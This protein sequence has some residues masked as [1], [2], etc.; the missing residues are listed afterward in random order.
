MRTLTRILAPA[1]ALLAMGWSSASGAVDFVIYNGDDPGIGFNDPTPATPVGGNPGTTLGQQRIN[2]YLRAFDLWG[3]VLSSSETVYV[4]AYWFEPTAAQCTPTSGVLGSA[5]TTF[6]FSDFPG[7]PLVGHWYHSSLA[8]KLAGADL[9]DGLELAPGAPYPDMVTQFNNNL[10]TPGCLTGSGWYYG[11]DNNEAPGQIDFLSVLM[12]E[13]A[14][15][16]GFSNFTNEGSGAFFNGV[17]DVYTAFTRDNITGKQ[18]DDP[19]MTNADRA[20]SGKSVDKMVWNGAS[21]VATADN[22]LAPYSGVEFTAPAAVAGQYSYAAATFGPPATP[23]NFAGDAVYA[24][25]GVGATYDACEPIVNGSAIAGKIALVDRGACTFVTKVKNAQDAGAKGAVVVNN[26][27]SGLPGMGGADPSIT[28]PSIGVTQ[29]VG[30]PIKD[31]GGMASLF[32]FVDPTR[33]VGADLAGNPLLYAPSVYAPGSSGSHFDVTASPNALMEPAINSDLRP[34]SNVDMT[35]AQFKDIGWDIANFSI[36]GCDAGV[37]AV[38]GNGDVLIGPVLR[39]LDGAGTKGQ[40]QSCTTQYLTALNKVGLISNK[41][42]GLLTS[43][44][45]R[46][47]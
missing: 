21:V 7:A 40:F 23:A 26:A 27:P 12:H 15:G 45:A 37:P 39:C 35:A 36:A 4:F 25:D 34:A 18:W 2:A 30:Q 6:V 8:D 38:T 24:E 14:H 9:L 5:G 13:V 1:A 20:A 11:L 31:A 19:T 43:C 32:V 47:K 22:V 10:G 44:A 16:L 41:A 28:I 33:K 46:L 42:K 29:A 17:P 3:A